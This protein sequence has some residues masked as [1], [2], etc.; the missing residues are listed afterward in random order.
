[1]HA[2]YLAYFGGESA[3]RKSIVKK[4]TMS[5]PTF[6]HPLSLRHGLR[7]YSKLQFNLPLNSLGLL[8]KD[9]KER[10]NNDVID[11]SLCSGIGNVN[12]LHSSYRYL[13]TVYSVEFEHMC[14][15]T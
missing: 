8:T 2:S 3:D 5:F 7:R 12:L 15:V 14:Y 4:F 1:M 10:G 11:L 6:W 13:Q 9:E